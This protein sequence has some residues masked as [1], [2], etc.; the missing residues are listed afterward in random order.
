MLKTPCVSFLSQFD[1]E[2]QNFPIKAGGI[3]RNYIGKSCLRHLESRADFIFAGLVKMSVSCLFL[4][5]SGAW[6]YVT[7]PSHGLLFFAA[8]AR[9][10]LRLAGFAPAPA[11]V[12]AGHDFP[13]T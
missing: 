10:G 3:K 13:S 12:R 5:A 11:E 8:P 2:L 1:I 7:L 4:L 9:Q 6:V